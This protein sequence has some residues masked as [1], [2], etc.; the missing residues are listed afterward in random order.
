M[1]PLEAALR[2]HADADGMVSPELLNRLLQAVGVPEKVCAKVVAGNADR[3]AVSDFL[4]ACQC[5][6]LVK[7]KLKAGAL[8]F[9][10]LCLADD[11]CLYSAP[12]YGSQVPILN[13]ADMSFVFIDGA[14]D[15]GGAYYGICAAANGRLYCAPLFAS[16]VLVIDPVRRS[17]SYIGSNPQN[18]WK[19]CRSP[20]KAVPLREDPWN[21][22]SGVAGTGGKYCGICPADNGRLYCAPFGSESV[23]VIDPL[24]GTLSYIQGVW[25]AGGKYCGI[26]AGNDGCLYCAPYCSSRVLVIDPKTD[27]LS[28]IDGAGYGSNKY[29]GICAGPDGRL[30]CA[31]ESSTRVLV[32]DTAS[33]SL[34]FIDGVQAGDCKY[35]GISAS[36]DGNLYCSPYRS[37]QVLVV[38]A[39]AGSCRRM[40]SEHGD[41]FRL[42]GG[43]C[44]AP[45]GRLYC[46]PSGCLGIT[47][48]DPGASTPLSIRGTT[49]Q[50]HASVG[51]C[52]T[53]PP[54]MM[55]T[56]N[57]VEGG[58]SRSGKG[59]GKG[60]GRGI[61][62]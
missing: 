9:R 16:Q 56:C 17:I 54:Q 26:C 41:G 31:P 14:S 4:R 40:A 29:C 35:D 32:I 38:D 30:Y 5:A 37:S 58:T 62:K 3:M 23:L 50:Q 44:A 8:S 22:W 60:R 18:S 7:P 12:Y 45:G 15:G 34:S 53:G 36:I 2:V 1:D 49:Q 46:A 20:A 24:A 43:I 11:G 28:Y 57:A 61:C 39:V 33:R 21:G 6:K 10:G 51:E 47:A 48:I 27:S 13:A 25:G 59:S 19:R 55:S 52:P 42:H